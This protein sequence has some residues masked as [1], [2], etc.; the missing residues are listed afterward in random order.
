MEMELNFLETPKGYI[1]PILYTASEGAGL[2][3]FCTRCVIIIYCA[4][5]LW[6]RHS[7][8]QLGFLSS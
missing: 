3:V 7:G 2:S 4:A 8:N 5:Y 1:L 6:Q